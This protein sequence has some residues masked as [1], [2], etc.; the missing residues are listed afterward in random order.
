M[1]NNKFTIMTEIED[2]LDNLEITYIRHKATY[3]TRDFNGKLHMSPA[4][5]NQLG[6]PDLFIVYPGGFL[7]TVYIKNSDYPTNLTGRQ[8]GWRNKLKA[9]STPVWIVTSLKEFQHMFLDFFERVV[10]KRSNIYNLQN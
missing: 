6:S 5:Q 2:W 3:V 10:E 1:K 7:V 9:L 8:A 4:K